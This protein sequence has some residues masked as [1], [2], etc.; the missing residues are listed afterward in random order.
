MTGVGGE[1]E[2]DNNYEVIHTIHRVLN[3]C[4]KVSGGACH[5]LPH[6]ESWKMC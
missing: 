2:K 6:K 3:T 1:R 4:V 5:Y